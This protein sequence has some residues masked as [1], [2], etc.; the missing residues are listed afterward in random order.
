MGRA[1]TSEDMSWKSKIVYFIIAMILI[2]GSPAIFGEGLDTEPNPEIESLSKP[3]AALIDADSSQI[4]G[5]KEITTTLQNTG[6]AGNLY[7][8]LWLGPAPT[9]GIPDTEAGMQERGYEQVRTGTYYFDSGERRTISFNVDSS[10]GAEGFA[11]KAFASTYTATVANSG[12]TGDV[13][14]SLLWTNSETDDSVIVSSRTTTIQE[15]GTL[16]VEFSVEEHH[17]FH[18]PNANFDMW[19]V[20]AEPA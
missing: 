5:G 3:T 1:A 9:D 16:E 7:V 13:N 15:D 12:G 6:E 11:V 17:G 18:Y 20:T 8:T 19:E 10:G 14:T 2:N 4:E